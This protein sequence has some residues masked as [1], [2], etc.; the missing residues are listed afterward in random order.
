MPVWTVSA[1]DFPD[2]ARAGISPDSVSD[3]NKV[4]I[5]MDY[6]AF[7]VEKA[8]LAVTEQRRNEILA[9]VPQLSGSKIQQ[10]RHRWSDA[11]LA[12]IVE[13]LKSGHLRRDKFPTVEVAG[14]LLTDFRGI[15]FRKVA[16]GNRESSLR[17]VW[18]DIDFSY[19]RV[20][21][22][23]GQ[24]MFVAMRNCTV[25][26]ADIPQWLSCSFDDCDFSRIKLHGGFM[27]GNFFKCRFIGTDFKN[28]TIGG[29]F[30]RCNF[31]AANLFKAEIGN[32]TQFRECLW[33]AS[34]LP[35]GFAPGS[36]YR[37]PRSQPNRK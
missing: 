10:L 14:K 30:D 25:L 11:D 9:T 15:T 1:R 2:L 32:T 26:H 5:S 35:P 3:R 7:F 4:G 6:A 31:S 29:T 19:C 12:N 27:A 24:L 28:V 13:M 34:A 8:G 33:D 36:H 23:I 37:T 20:G 17:P 16:P 21:D 22:A 18:E